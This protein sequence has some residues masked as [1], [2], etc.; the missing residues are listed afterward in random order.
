ME[1][2]GQFHGVAQTAGGEWATRE[3]SEDYDS[4]HEVA[5]EEDEHGEIGEVDYPE[6]GREKVICNYV[7]TPRQ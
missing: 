2:P 6:A 1:D 7:L 5:E 4:V 3:A